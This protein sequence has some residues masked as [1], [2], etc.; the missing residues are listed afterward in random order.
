MTEAAVA[1]ERA[2]AGPAP[3][4][5]HAGGGAAAGHPGAARVRRRAG[6]PAAARLPRS[7]SASA[8]FEVGVDRHR[9]PGRLRRCSPSSSACTPTASRRAALL[10]GA[11]PA[12]G[13][14]RRRLR[15]GRRLLAAAPGRVRRH[16]QPV[17]GRRQRVP[18]AR[19][20]AA[21]A[22]ASAD[23]DRTALFARYSLVGIARRR[24]S[25]RSC[26]GLPAAR[27]RRP[28]RRPRGGAAG[29]VPALRRA[30]AGLR[31]SLY[32]RLP[33]P[34]PPDAAT[35]PPQPLGPSRRIVL[36][37]GG[38]VQP[39][40]VR[41][42]PRRAVAAGAVAVRA[43][44]PLAGHDGRDLLLDRRCSRPL[45]YLAAVPHRAA[46]RAGQHDGVHPPAGERLPR[47]SC[48]FAPSLGVGR[49][50]AAGAQRAVADGRADAHL[51]RHGGGRRRASARRRRA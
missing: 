10:L 31:C 29:A 41:R 32:R 46:H 15:P 35:A 9:D 36:T 50:A 22:R 5:R 27:W 43:L 20:G 48:P 49:R 24:A 17:G 45:S 7:R 8:P 39:R 38:A 19:A 12:D 28:A 47:R 51:V 25:A 18:A 4:E 44:R 21:R 11:A 13:A 37:A 2:A 30:R 1:G 33:R 34:R 23:R 6:Q 3:G 42:R 40:R 16:A 14:H 26:A